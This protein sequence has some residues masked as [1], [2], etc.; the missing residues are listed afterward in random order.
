MK[1]I[2]AFRITDDEGLR[3][4]KAREL[5]DITVSI[6]ADRDFSFERKRETEIAGG[7]AGAMKEAAQRTFSHVQAK[8]T[9]FGICAAIST[10]ENT[11]RGNRPPWQSSRG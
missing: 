6:T 1:R 11:R 9:E 10:F 7:I 2:A 4:V 3:C 8:K 5:D